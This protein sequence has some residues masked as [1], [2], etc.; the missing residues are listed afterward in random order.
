VR[1]GRTSLRLFAGILLALS[2][3][4]TLGALGTWA[5]AAVNNQYACC[6]IPYFAGFPVP[7]Y[8]GSGGFAGGGVDRLL[9]GALIRSYLWWFGLVLATIVVV[10][11]ARRGAA[12]ARRV[13]VGAGVTLAVFL[14]VGLAAAEAAGLFMGGSIEIALTAVALALVVAAAAIAI[15][16]LV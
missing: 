3:A 11:R 13:W 1:D 2:A 14:G 15:G 16:R 9:P 8:G 10:A 5:S 7:F 6:D 4:V 12:P